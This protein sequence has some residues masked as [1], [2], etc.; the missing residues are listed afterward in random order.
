LA[1]KHLLEA[2]ESFSGS[3][4][5]KSKLYLSLS[6]LFIKEGNLKSAQ[7][8][9]S[10]AEQVSTAESLPYVYLTK[11][12]IAFAKEQFSSSYQNTLKALVFLQDKEDHKGE[13]YVY[14]LLC[15]IYYELEKYRL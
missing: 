2:E 15:K 10:A 1:I 3:N 12:K 11:G 14:G 4:S 5:E 6:D 9:I 7:K 13:I 8:Y